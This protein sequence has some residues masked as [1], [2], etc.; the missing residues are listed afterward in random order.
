MLEFV[1]HIVNID[2]PGY[3]QGLS[4]SLGFNIRVGPKVLLGLCYKKFSITGR[5]IEVWQC[6]TSGP[7]MLGN[8]PRLS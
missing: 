4:R 8:K 3:G 7:R 6:F 2:I 5:G 1:P